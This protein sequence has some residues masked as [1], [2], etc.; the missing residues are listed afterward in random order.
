[1]IQPLA[2]GGIIIVVVI[3]MLMR[4]EDLRD[5]FIR[6][7]G[8]GDLHRTT[9]AL[10]DAGR[11]VGQYLLMQLVVNITYALPVGIGLWLIGVPNAPLW[12]LLALVL[13]FVPYIGPIVASILP[14]ILA[15]AVDPGWTMLF[16]TATLFIALELVSNN[17]VEPWLY[18]SRTGLSSLAIIVSAIFWTWLW[19]PLGLLLSTP[20]TVCLVVLGRHVPQF[21]FLDVLLGSDPVLEPHEQLYQRFLAGDPYEATDRAETFLKEEDLIT[22]YQTVAIPALGLGERDRARGVMSDDRRKRVAETAAA[23][24]E[25][26]ETIADDEASDEI[27]ERS[28]SSAEDIVLD[29]AAGKDSALELPEG[30]GK[31]VLCAGGRGELDDAAAAMLAQILTVQG[32]TSRMIEHHML[33]PGRIRELDLSGSQSIVIGFLNENS[34]SHAR[35]MVRRLKRSQRSL[36]V[37]VLFWTLEDNEANRIKLIAS[38]HCDFVARTMSEAIV[39]AL[40]D[41][42]VVG[43]SATANRR[44]SSKTKIRGGKI[45]PQPG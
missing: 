17:V 15:L 42:P 6:L 9:A 39:G 12:G 25:N 1:L 30:E 20:L 24:I 33:T 34:I 44:A 16:W 35:Y 8:A 22:F 11:R 14:L 37:G 19:G 23:L 45:A 40:S 2:T 27:A 3:F 32:A 28:D 31:T 4:R 7:V 36:R 13:R 41:E 29:Q 18:G 26:L 38:I 10:Q 43:V 21:E 5:R